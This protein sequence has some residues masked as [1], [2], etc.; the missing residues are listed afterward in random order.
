M[1]QK[2]LITGA[3]G[4]IG[5]CLV[6]HFTEHGFICRAMIKN[7][8]KIPLEKAA[9]PGAEWVYGDVT[10]PETLGPVTKD[11]KIV[12]HLAA[13]GHVATAAERDRLH[14]DEVNVGGTRNLARACLQSEVRRFFHFSSTAAVGLI[15]NRLVDETMPPKP[16]TPYQRSKHESELV[17][18]EYI[19]K[20]DFPGV[21]FR[22]CM[23]YGPGSL[24]EF[25]KFTKLVKKGLLPKIGRRTKFTPIVHV[26]DVIQA[27]LKAM[28]R[29]PAGRCYF[30]CGKQS[31][32]FDDI[33]E[34]IRNNIGIQR[35]ALVIP[36]K[37][38]LAAAGFLEIWGKLGRKPPLAT[39]QNI[40]STIADRHFSIERAQK[41]FGYEPK[42]DLA[43]G[44]KEVIDWYRKNGYIR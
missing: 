8:N 10:L 28:D 21:I 39:R 44:I 22:P 6:R 24:G 3:G 12:F 43:Q 11:I 36:E 31:F 17:I 7:R 42:K 38:A 15:P 37:L 1:K 2:I 27:C 34:M 32:P 25:F 9:L 35:P 33:I 13:K 23:V 20:Y 19:N 14:F 41:D 18:R 4:F 30:I 5:R 26:Q 40:R 16:V 29:A